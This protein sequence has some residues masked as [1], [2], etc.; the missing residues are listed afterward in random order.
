[1]RYLPEKCDHAL[2]AGR[3]IKVLHEFM[4][5]NGQFNI[6]VSFPCW[7]AKTV[8][9]QIVFVSPDSNL[10]DFLLEQPYFQVMIDNGLFEASDVEDVP[11]SESFVKFVRNQSIDKMTPA[12]KARRLRRAQKRAIARGEEFDPIPPQ[13]KEVDFFHSIP[14]ESSESGMSYMLRVQR[15]EAH[16]VSKVE[17][18]KVCSYG[19]STNESHEALIPYCVA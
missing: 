15:F 6:A 18:F 16:R 9:N 10:L 12:A 5:R 2:L 13:S 8:G 14:M 19:L 3:C 7:S 11:K 1:M 17:P 4:S